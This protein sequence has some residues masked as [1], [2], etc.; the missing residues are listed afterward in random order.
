MTRTTLNKKS[1]TNNIKKIEYLIIFIVIFLALSRM[2]IRFAPNFINIE[3]SFIQI[4]VEEASPSSYNVF[5]AGAVL[6]FVMIYNFLYH[7]LDKAEYSVILAIG[8]VVG[9]TVSNLIDIVFSGQLV[10]YVKLWGVLN[11]N[12]ASIFMIL[13]WVI[14]IGT[15]IMYSS[16]HDLKLRK[17]Y[18]E[19]DEE[20]AT[21]KS[22]KIDND[23]KIK[24]ATKSKA[25]KNN[26][27]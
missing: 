4:K 2:A 9:G 24:N 10:N 6:L 14:W 15:L 21:G 7:Q 25:K 1:I 22:S 11:T 18:E 5:I 12:I 13:G 19:Q 17:V 23:S 27:K 3:N 16:M 8:M 20:L 26:K